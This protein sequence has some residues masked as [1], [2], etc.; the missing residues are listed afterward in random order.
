MKSRNN[1][2]FLAISSVFIGCGQADHTLKQL[3]K[4]DTLNT[5]KI[6]EIKQDTSYPEFMTL[7]KL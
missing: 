5:S 7:W 4:Q 2:I 6:V 1:I 3:P